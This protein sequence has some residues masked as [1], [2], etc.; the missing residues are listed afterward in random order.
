MRSGFVTV[1]ANPG[2]LCFQKCHARIQFVARIAVQAFLR[3]N[4]G[5]VG[6]RSR[7]IVVFHQIPSIGCGAL[8]VNRGES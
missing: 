6:A 2:Y 7:A 8:A 4:T 1:G 3:E 5:G